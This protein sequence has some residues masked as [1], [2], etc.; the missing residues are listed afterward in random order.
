MSTAFN[1]RKEKILTGLSQDSP[2]AS[3]K[4][5]IDHEILSLVN[6]LNSQ[7]GIVTTSS[8][9]G[10]IAIFLEGV[11]VSSDSGDGPSEFDNRAFT[12]TD[13]ENP[14]A[15]EEKPQIDNG[16]VLRQA[17]IGGK[18]TGGKWIFVSHTPIPSHEVPWKISDREDFQSDTARSSNVVFDENTR[19]LHFKFEPMV[20]SRP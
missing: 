8:C 16:Q 17:G 18:G 5:F 19:Y 1:Q 13:T 11:K 12:N 7:D 10:R 15:S 9:A 20:C 14:T 4:G 6:Y 3:P 2:D